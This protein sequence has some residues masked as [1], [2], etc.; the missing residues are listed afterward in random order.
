MLMSD[1]HNVNTGNHITL[2]REN[3]RSNAADPLKL[4][5][6]LVPRRGIDMR[7]NI[8]GRQYTCDCEPYAGV[9]EETAR[10][11]S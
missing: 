6:V 8:E 2:N 7:K 4:W 10:T 3:L 1:W 11:N 5:H 9:R